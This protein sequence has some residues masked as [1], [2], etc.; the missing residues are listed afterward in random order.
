VP[1]RVSGH[2]RH[3][4]EAKFGVACQD[5][6]LAAQCTTARQ[7][8]TITIGPHE[9]RL[10]T[11]RQAQASPAWKADYQ[12]TRPKA[13]RK[14][15]HLMRRRH[16]GRRARV[17]GQ[18]KVAAGFACSPPLSTSPGSRCLASPQT[19]EPGQQPGHDRPRPL[20]HAI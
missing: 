19:A 8:R 3:A 16:G 15:G 1:I 2:K 12:A 5:C 7:G 14:I 17:R 18:V 6:L 13:E 10:A 20:A 9:A 4:G 11:A